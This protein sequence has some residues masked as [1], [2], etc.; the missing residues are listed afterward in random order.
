MNR[1]ILEEL[2]QHLIA[3]AF[4]G[5]NLAQFKQMSAKDVRPR[6]KKEEEDFAYAQKEH[7]EI[8]YAKQHLPLLGKGSSR[9]T[10]ALNSS[11]VLKIAM[12]TAGIAQNEA[13]LDVFTHN[14][15]N[16]L[17]TKIFDYAPDLKWIISEIVKEFDSEQ[18][19]EKFSHVPVIILDIMRYQLAQ[20]AGITSSPDIL[21]GALEDGLHTDLSYAQRNAENQY[22]HP[23]ERREYVEKAEKTRALL[24]N[25]EKIMKD[26]VAYSFIAG[27]IRMMQTHKLVSGDI[28]PYHFG[29]TADGHIRM[30]DS[31]ATQSV[32]RKHY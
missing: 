4:G 16:A 12:N 19:F 31:G 10:F 26:S 8:A 2:I 25:L 1:Q 23:E 29:R 7:P 11:K 13:E 5:F 24:L 18:E 14:Q 30:L 22:F 27:V 21:M 20:K 9:I 32:M 6:D 3:E 28:V 17:V 15:D